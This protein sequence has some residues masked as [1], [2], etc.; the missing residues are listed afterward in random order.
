MALLNEVK[1]VLDR[2]GRAGWRNYLLETQG[3]D[4]CA[5]E[6]AAELSKDL[7][8]NREV[9]GFEDF[10]PQG[11]RA[12]EPG[13]PA[14]SLLYH[15]LASR[16]VRPALPDDAYPSWTDLDCLENYIYGLAPLSE[17]DMEGA[18]VAVLAYEYRTREVTTHRQHADL[19]FS[20]TGL[21]RVGTGE[22]L[23]KGSERCYTPV[24]GDPGNIAVLPARYGVFLAKFR[25]GTH[26]Q[27]SLLGDEVKGDGE[28]LF[29]YPLRKLFS[30]SECLP[31]R[32]LSI[33]FAESHR[34]EK[35][36]RVVQHATGARVPEGLDINQPPFFRQSPDPELVRMEPV[37]ATV[38]ISAPPGP[39]VREAWQLNS[40]TGRQERA[41]FV[42]PPREDFINGLIKDPIN[43]HYTALMIL[44]S[45]L[46][47]AGE[48]IQGL[49]H[50][51]NFV[52]RNAP[53][54]VHIRRQV[55]A[56]QSMTDLNKEFPSYSGL[57]NKVDAG[58][59][60]AALFEDGVCDGCV[61]AFVDGLG[62]TLLPTQP[63]YSVIAA[64]SFF[65]RSTEL[66]LENWTEANPH[67]FEEGSAQPL[68]EGRHLV[69]PHILLPR[70]D[71]TPSDVRAFSLEDTVVA[72][73]GRPYGV[74]N[75]APRTPPLVFST[76]FLTDAGSHEF[77]PGW[78]VTVAN[79]RN[80]LT[81]VGLLEKGRLYY[82]T[83]GLGAPYPEDVKFCSAANGFWPSA[84][85]DAARTFHRSDTPTSIL[86]LDRE[87]GYHPQHPEVLAGKIKSEP[88]WDGGYGPFFQAHESKPG[89]NFGSL[90]HTDYVTAS[91]EHRFGRA[92][93]GDLTADVLIERMSCHR[94]CI[95]A[96]DQNAQVNNT[97]YWMISAEEKNWDQEPGSGL[98]GRGY[99]FEYA[100]AS[101]DN[102]VDVSGQY[103]RSW[104]S[105]QPTVYTCQVTVD[106]VVRH[107]TR[108][109]PS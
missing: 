52:P 55:N 16:N 87:L 82:T 90:S 40:K 80:G 12:I 58:N 93:F 79:D 42:V 77:F 31:G 24:T 88:G 81:D 105:I 13:D 45:R 19:A 30:G 102:P 62:P 72:V 65:P 48:E 98:S 108:T 64:P 107:S 101:K 59:Y 67:Q 9:P 66:D 47:A 38:K 32:E 20:R 33:Q 27:V 3:L 29:L 53:E 10:A 89:V 17:Q 106:G 23:Y 15:A 73:M 85:P 76:S 39:I 35:L 69:N 56:D 21:A 36:R 28:R 5:P 103:D 26:D 37:G 51:K 71:G 7:K 4:I 70:R 75:A 46:D 96:I 97:G 94:K 104:Q 14:R 34:S 92:L 25:S 2:L 41:R 100:L 99:L 43:R 63:A 11:Q 84:S 78:D 86:L 109:L 74:P 54:F 50:L 49:L 61:T 8:V 95:E 6:L 57:G 91:L 83:F 1:T 44:G 22:A 60:E 68:C 18:V